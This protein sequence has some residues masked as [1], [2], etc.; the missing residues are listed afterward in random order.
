MDMAHEG[1]SHRVKGVLHINAVG[2]VTQYL[3]VGTVENTSKDFL[4]PVLEG[5]RQAFPFPAPRLPLRQRLRVDQPHRGGAAAQ[6][7]RRRVHQV[8]F[9]PQRRQHAV[10]VEERHH[11][12]SGLG[13]RLHR[14]ALRRPSARI[15][16]RVTLALSELPPSLLFRARVGRRLGAG[17]QTP[18]LP[19][20]AHA[21]QKFNSLAGAAELLRP[22]M[23]LEQL[24]AAAYARSDHEAVGQLYAALAALF[25]ELP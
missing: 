6:T 3:D 25:L 1:K 4:L 16:P 10:R 20:H 12:A 11:G 22:G 2:E 24:D 8:V 7:A 23:R 21:L 9:P 19:R 14:L 15:Q 17:T 18:P 13:P 5:L